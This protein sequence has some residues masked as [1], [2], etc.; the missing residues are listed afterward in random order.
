MTQAIDKGIGLV[1]NGIRME[2]IANKNLKMVKVSEADYQ[3]LRR[4]KRAKKE[5][6]A[7]VL[8]LFDKVKK[9]ESGNLIETLKTK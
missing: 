4:D 1:Y 8:M 6:K 3:M 7:L 9:W 5:I 2:N